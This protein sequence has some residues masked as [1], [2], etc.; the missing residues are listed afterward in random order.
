MMFDTL[1]HRRFAWVHVVLGVW[2]C[3]FSSYALS[4]QTRMQVSMAFA[5]TATTAAAATQDTPCPD[6][7]A[8]Q[9]DQA[10]QDGQVNDHDCPI[11]HLIG[12]GWVQAAAAAPVHHAAPHPAPH[13]RLFQ[14]VEYLQTADSPPPSF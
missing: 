9:H 6:H 8:T 4:M 11:C 5:A 2:L 13:G 1:R 7:V 3:V 14:A 12:S 10:P